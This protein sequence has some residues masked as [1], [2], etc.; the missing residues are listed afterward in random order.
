ML[1]LAQ[2]SNSASRTILFSITLFLSAALMF[3]VQLIIG[4]MMLP[5]VGGSPNGWLV[6]M[7]FFQLALLAGYAGAHA[8]TRFSPLIHIGVVIGV[9]VIGLLSL[10]LHLGGGLDTKL[11]PIAG[12][13]VWSLLVSITLP[14]LGLSMLSPSMQR[15]FAS[16]GQRDPYFLFAASNLGSFVGLLS[17]PLVFE[18]VIGLAVQSV[19][20]QAGYVVLIV[21]CGLCLLLSDRKLITL[22]KNTSKIFDID[23]RTGLK[24]IGLAF[25]PSSLTLGITSQITMDGGSL[26][27]FWVLPLAFYLLTFVLA[28]SR[29]GPTLTRPAAF[30]YPMGL[31]LLVFI[32][33]QQPLMI[34]WNLKDVLPQIIG[35]CLVTLFCHSRLAEIRPAPQKLTGYYLCVA[36]GGALGGFFNVFIA[37]LIFPLPFEFILVAVAACFAGSAGKWT[38]ST[39]VK[40][41]LLVA[42]LVGFAVLIT[43]NYM[44][45]STKELIRVTPL[46]SFASVAALG[47]WIFF[48]RTKTA[49][50]AK[51]MVLGPLLALFAYMVVDGIYDHLGNEPLYYTLALALFLSLIVLALHSKVFLLVAGL[52][53]LFSLAMSD[54]PSLLEVKRNFFGIL[55][56][57]TVPHKDYL[58][59]YFNNG[60]T[61]HG[62]QKVHP[63]I[64][65]RPTSYYTPDGPLGDIM[66]IRNPRDVGMIGMGAGTTV[67]YQAKNRHFTVYDINP[68]VPVLA[69]KWFYFFQYCGRPEIKIGDGRKLIQAA[70]GVQHDVL[71]VDAFSSD[72]IPV[73]LMTKEAVQIYFDHLSPKGILALHL[74]SRYYELIR[75]AFAVGQAL[76]MQTYY[77]F[78]NP[79]PNATPDSPSL[80]VIIARPKVDLGAYIERGWRTLPALAS[81]LWT[82]DFSH[83]LSLVSIKSVLQELS[84][85]KKN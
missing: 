54:A 16:S 7:A 70:T 58:M 80:W 15:L 78:Y 57:R 31:A 27:F 69:D 2:F 44:G 13:V 61:V 55:H 11:S 82:D 36:I 3:L 46:L 85:A 71:I 1:A 39:A 20:W 83:P 59:R 14:F 65:T 50:R 23:W 30:L 41:A 73:H 64:D 47:A 25:I 72:S 17:Y 51:W 26:P 81:D 43:L 24:W 37:P 18:R 8:L 42:A 79:P 32:F 74:T 12:D 56:I 75:P 22:S 21:L 52:L 67:C 35:F 10:P 53:S 49:G 34:A 28:F 9:L 5:M 40:I 62:I 76:G 29:F 19:A 33:V 45:S 77:K 4:K 48:D 63:Q 66:D 84:Y 68:D 38:Q 60:S 6:A